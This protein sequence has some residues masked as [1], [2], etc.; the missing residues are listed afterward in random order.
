MSQTNQAARPQ[1]RGSPDFDALAGRALHLVARS[2][3]GRE[4]GPRPEARGSDILHRLVA[5]VCEAD[6]GHRDV[7]MAEMSAA[8]IS[9]EEIID[10][11]IPGAARL[12]GEAWCEDRASFT[13][14]TI[15][16]ARLQG[17]LREL[18]DRRGDALSD[19]QGSFDSPRIMV[20]VR[21]D[22]FFTLGPACCGAAACAG[23][24]FRLRMVIGRKP[25]F[26]VPL[27]GLHATDSTD[28]CRPR[29]AGKTLPCG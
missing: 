6:P 7:V 14:V 24:G 12:L 17:L 8:G 27:L 10:S 5:A 4:R 11:Y 2:G 28:C 13:D 22:A 3:D 16:V 25:D 9:P 29:V 1:Q 18:G 20:I 21:Q 19:A 23:W 26:E 15:G